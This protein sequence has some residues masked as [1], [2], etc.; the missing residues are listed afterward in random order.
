MPFISCL[1][2]LTVNVSKMLNRSGKSS[3]SYPV[4]DLRGKAFII[5]LS[6]MILAVCFLIDVLYQVTEVLYYF[7]FVRVFIRNGCWIL[8]SLF[9]ASFETLVY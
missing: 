2:K 3:H 7:Y 5:S 8:S 6:N 9:S 1:I 4:P